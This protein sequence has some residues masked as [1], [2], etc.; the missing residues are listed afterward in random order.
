[1]QT[2]VT[3]HVLELFNNEL[4]GKVICFTLEDSLGFWIEMSFCLTSCI[5]AV[6]KSVGGAVV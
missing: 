6:A 3:V 5:T 4:I 1:M 2:V